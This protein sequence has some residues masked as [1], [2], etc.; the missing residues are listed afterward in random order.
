MATSPKVTARN[1][2]ELL[3]IK[4]KPSNKAKKIRKKKATTRNIDSKDKT[5]NNK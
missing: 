5:N 2:A 3:K 4:S 1:V